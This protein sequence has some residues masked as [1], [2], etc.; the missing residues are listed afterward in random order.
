M[1]EKGDFQERYRRVGQVL[2]EH[3]HLSGMMTDEHQG[4]IDAMLAHVGG[5]G[6][7]NSLIPTD[8][9]PDYELEIGYDDIP[10]ED[11]EG[12]VP[13]VPAGAPDE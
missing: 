13:R 11:E 2:E 10:A 7:T 8:P 6:Y 5:I 12:W 9:T 4:Y 3:P 1:S